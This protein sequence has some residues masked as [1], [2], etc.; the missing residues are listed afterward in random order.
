[1]VTINFPLKP[2][3]KVLIMERQKVSLYFG[4]QIID[5]GSDRS[6]QFVTF[7]MELF[8]WLFVDLL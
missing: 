5:D 3:Q 4:L 8:L 1:M 2:L 7:K 6:I